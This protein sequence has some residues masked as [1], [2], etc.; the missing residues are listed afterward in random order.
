M[1]REQCSMFFTMAWDAKKFWL[2]TVLATE[3]LATDE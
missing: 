2:V 1:F 3:V